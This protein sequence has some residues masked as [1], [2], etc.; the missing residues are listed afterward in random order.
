ML[1]LIGLVL[2]LGI[3]SACTDAVPRGGGDIVAIGDSV[4]A[5]NGSQNRS[6]PDALSAS[7]Q[8]QVISRAVPG[9]QFDNGSGLAGAVG[10]DVRRQM[11]GGQWN[12]V[13][14][15]GG[16]NDLSSDCGC[17]A[18]GPVVDA[19]IGP[20]A[21]TGAI[22]AFI[23]RVRAQSGARVM[24]MGY[25][26]G[27][28]G[29]SFQGCRKYLVEMETRIARFAAATPGVE[30]VDSED[31]IDRRD[32]ALFASDNTHP[33]ARASALI[34]AYLAREMTAREARSQTGN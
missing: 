20:G 22:P 32:P 25:Y 16:A 28:G 21:D 9:A 17:G 30:F 2:G 27:P 12:W 18:C 24:W 15:N 33:S 13:L 31:V 14:M 6:I 5:W 7:L 4:M 1:R 29:G 34:G 26:A 10:F 11:P 8:R 3:L 23:A 19:L